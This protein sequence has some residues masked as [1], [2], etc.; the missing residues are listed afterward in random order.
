[1][2][3]VRWARAGIRDIVINTFYLAE[4]IENYLGDGSSMVS[5]FFGHVKLNCWKRVAVL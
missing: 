2:R 1:M 5:R 4:Q 3:C